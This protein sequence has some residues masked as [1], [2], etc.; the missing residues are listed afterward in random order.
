LVALVARGRGSSAQAPPVPARS[1]PPATE[2]AGAS[3]GP[4]PTAAE[5]T[6]T[7]KLQQLKE[8]LDQGLITEAE[9]Q[10]KKAEILDNF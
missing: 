10:A 2:Q 9:Y 3:A 6:P 4:P 1:A 8:M 5:P 7:Q